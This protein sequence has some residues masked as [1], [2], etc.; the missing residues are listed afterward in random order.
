MWSSKD[1]IYLYMMVKVNMA[2]SKGK[3][4]IYLYGLVKHVI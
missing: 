1:R 4:I 3:D 2:S